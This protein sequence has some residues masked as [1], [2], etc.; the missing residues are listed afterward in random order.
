[1]TYF[2]DIVTSLYLFCTFHI[3][4]SVPD[5]LFP[6]FENKGKPFWHQTGASHGPSLPILE[7]NCSTDR[8]TILKEVRASTWLKLS[9][10]RARFV[11]DH[12]I[13]FWL[14]FL[15]CPGLRFSFWLVSLVPKS[16]CLWMPWPCPSLSAV[17]SPSHHLARP[18]W[19]PESHL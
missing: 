12:G 19:V 6:L 10:P 18:S 1:M 7:E 4:V 15:I 5:M 14:F 16:C 13:P 8:Q 2:E 3:I 11:V 17:T 9:F